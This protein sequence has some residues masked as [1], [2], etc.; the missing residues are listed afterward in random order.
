VKQIVTVRKRS[1]R[2]VK[3]FVIKQTVG[4]ME[5]SGAGVPIK[6]H[7]TYRYSRLPKLLK[8]AEPK[9]GFGSGQTVRK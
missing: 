4:S 7:Q 3:E 6:R 1:M 9:L 8:L 5:L 2:Q